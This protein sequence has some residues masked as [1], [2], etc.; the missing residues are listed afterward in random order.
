[1]LLNLSKVEIKSQTGNYKV[2]IQDTN[3]LQ[4]ENC[5]YLIDRKVDIGIE[6][7][8]ERVVYLDVEE[9]EKT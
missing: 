6:I 5:F 8:S 1:M 9:R 3:S 2:L 4:S 7:S